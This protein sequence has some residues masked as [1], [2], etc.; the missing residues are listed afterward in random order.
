M[1][2]QKYCVYMHINK[3][4]KKKYIGI[5]CKNPKIRWNN[6]KGYRHNEYFYRAIIKYGWENFDHIILYSAL[7]KTDACEL[8]IKLIKQFNTQDH[9]YGYN[10]MGGGEHSL[11]TEESRMKMRGRHLDELSKKNIGLNNPL[12]RKV[13]CEG[14][15]YISVRECAK[16]YGVNENSMRDWL[17]GRTATP[18]KFYLYNLRYSDENP[19]YQKIKTKTFE[20]ICGD[21]IFNSIRECAKFYNVTVSSMSSW[22]SNKKEMP[23]KFQQLNL[24]YG[25]IYRY[26]AKPTKIQKGDTKI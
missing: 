26:I 7:S 24:H 5:T 4:N 25:N 14:N 12:A 22:L 3:I 10:I 9:N 1:E 11:H 8:E 16:R 19:N 17:K 18:E 2:N 21:L 15:L 6:G 23:I 13:Y 20:V